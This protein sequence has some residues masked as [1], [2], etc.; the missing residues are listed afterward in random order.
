[1]QYPLHLIRME[2]AMEHLESSLWESRRNVP[3]RLGVLVGA[4][5]ALLIS[6][7]GGSTVSDDIAD[8]PPTGD[9]APAVC[10]TA[11]A[12]AEPD[13]PERKGNLVPLGATE[14]LLCSYPVTSRDPAPHGST[15][16]LTQEVDALTKHLN[17]LPDGAPD[18]PAC[19]LIGRTDYAIVFGYPDRPPATVRLGEC[20]TLDQNGATRYG[21]GL[22]ELL[23]FW[24]VPLHN[25]D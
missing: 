10:P 18:D 12:S 20:G 14:A 24:N 13:R 17:S 3:P 6:G 25:S 5:I 7:C 22:E 2:P 1:M 8:P 9:P 11:W 15:W 21:Y 16:R 23:A 19:F 4:A